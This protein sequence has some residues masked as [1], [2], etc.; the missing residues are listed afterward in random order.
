V[1]PLSLFASSGV[2][3][4]VGA[5]VV[6]VSVA[7]PGWGPEAAVGVLGP[8]GS[9]ICVGGTCGVH[10]NCG[11]PLALMVNRTGSVIEHARSLFAG[12][13]SAPAIGPEAS[14]VSLQRASE[15]TRTAATHASPLSGQ[16]VD[17]HRGFASRAQTGLNVSGQADAALATQVARASAVVQSGASQLEAIAAE[18]AQ[19]RA[20]AAGARTP[21]AQRAVVTALRSQAERTDTVV[22]STLENAQ[23]SAG[24]IQ[25][26]DWKTGPAPQSPAPE[27]PGPVSPY[28]LPDPDIPIPEGKEWHYY[29]S[30]GWRLED[31]LEDC[32]A[33][34]EFWTL[35][36]IV[37][38]G[39]AMIFGGPLGIIGGFVTAGSG[40]YTINQCAPPFS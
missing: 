33:G 5:S 11:M 30:W 31:K 7:A 38:G 37:A 21:A 27:G 34:K 8:G 32:S 18:H 4:A 13:G 6:V 15:A 19:T 29:T 24:N 14:G 26:I 1:V 25:A 35:A 28:P 2:V 22:A 12:A 39:A 36:Q 9:K 17:G 20:L 3:A 10:E 16:F 40:I 23:R